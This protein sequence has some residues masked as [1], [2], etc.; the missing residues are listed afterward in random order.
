MVGVGKACDKP[1][2]NHV[3]EECADHQADKAP[4]P[5][6]GLRTAPDIASE[7]N[8]PYGEKSGAS[9]MQFRCH[10]RMRR[11][12]TEIFAWEQVTLPV[13][14]LHGAC[15]ADGAVLAKSGFFTGS[16]PFV[17]GAATAIARLG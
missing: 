13:F 16:P 5:F 4:A 1:M 12:A 7:G 15:C 6:P 3:A 11:D 10:G 9:P 14:I 2:P 8:A 17:S